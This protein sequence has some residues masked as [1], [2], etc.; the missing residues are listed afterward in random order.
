MSL[1]TLGRK[2]RSITHRY[3]TT[4]IEPV[5]RRPLTREE[6][7]TV[8]RALTRHVVLGVLM[9]GSAVYGLIMAVTFT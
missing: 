5:V 9:A 1:A 3:D 6:E 2:P 4:T 8:G 7:L